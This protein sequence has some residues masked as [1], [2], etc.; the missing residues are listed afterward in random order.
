[1]PASRATPP[2]RPTRGA[3]LTTALLF[4]TALVAACDRGTPDPTPAPVSPPTP[5]RVAG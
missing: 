3:G 1:M 5:P 4:V 2:A